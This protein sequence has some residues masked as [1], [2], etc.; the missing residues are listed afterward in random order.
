MYLGM[1]LL[2]LGVALVH[3][4]LI[5]FVF[6]VVFGFLMELLFTPFEDTNLERV[7]GKQYL[8]YK[9]SVRQWTYLNACMTMIGNAN[10]PA[11]AHLYSS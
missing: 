10:V 4:K 11:S 7:S 3:G 2:L 9:Q 8:E 6:P 1:V 5:S